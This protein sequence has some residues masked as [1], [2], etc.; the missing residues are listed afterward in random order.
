MSAHSA[1][2]IVAAVLASGL[3]TTGAQTV[4]RTPDVPKFMGREVTIME[5]EIEDGMFPKGPATLC[6]EGPPTRQCYTAPKDFGRNAQVVVV[7]LQKDTPALLFSV[8]NGGVSGWSIRFALLVPGAGSDLQDLFLSDM[9]FANQSQHSIWNERAISDLP[10]FV[11]ADYVWG[12]DEGHYGEHRYIIS[13]YFPALSPTDESFNY[14]LQDRYMT[15]RKYDLDA[16]ADLLASEKPEILARLKR[17]V[18]AQ[19]ARLT[20]PGPIR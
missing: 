4:R 13:A 17:V 7:Q 18:E 14:Y 20:P 12:P 19:K 9:S 6:V 8:E 11:V 2:G 15:T 10:I 1:S 16:G 5:P 3:M